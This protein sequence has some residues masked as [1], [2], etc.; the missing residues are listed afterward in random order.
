V[1]NKLL[2]RAS[3]LVIAL[4]TATAVEAGSAGATTRRDA[5]TPSRSLATALHNQRRAPSELAREIAHRSAHGAISPRGV[6]VTH[7][8]ESNFDPA[9]G[10]PNSISCAT[11]SN[12]VM[13][14][15]AGGVS[16]YNGSTWSA[17]T[18]VDA[19][20]Q[21]ASISCPTSTFCAATDYEGNWLFD[22][23]GTWTTPTPFNATTPADN[24]AESISC[25]S[26]TFCV[27]VGY[28]QSGANFGTEIDFWDGG[29]WYAQSGGT[30]SDN[31]SAVSCKSTSFCLAVTYFG[32]STVISNPHVDPDDATNELVDLTTPTAIDGTNFVSGMTSVSCASTTYCAAGTNEGY[33]EVYNGA[34][35]TTTSIFQSFVAAGYVS[36]PSVTSGVANA[37]STVCFAMNEAGE[38]A[39]SLGNTS[40]T[41]GPT[42]SPLSLV[43]GLTCADTANCEASDF[44]GRIWA[45]ALSSVFPQVTATSS[46]GTFD[47]PHFMSGLSCTSSTLCV[48][49]D[50][51]GN[52]FQMTG[53]T[54]SS[55]VP[56][57]ARPYGI[58]TLACSPFTL[59]KPICTAFDADG[60]QYI[61]DGTSWSSSKSA[62]HVF[63]DGFS[64]TSGSICWGVDDHFHAYHFVTRGSAPATTTMPSNDPNNAQPMGLS[65]VN[66]TKFCA[67]IDD[68]GYG[69]V[70]TGTTWSATKAFDNVGTPTAISCAS[71]TFCMVVDDGGRAFTWNGKAWSGARFVAKDYLGAVSCSS[72]FRCVASDPDGIGYIWDGFQWTE[73][74]VINAPGDGLATLSCAT[75]NKCEAVNSQNLFTLTVTPSKTTSAI[76]PISAANRVVDHVAPTVV[77]TGSTVPFGT[78]TIT[79]GKVSCTAVLTPIPTAASKSSATCALAVPNVGVTVVSAVYHGALAT[80]PSLTGAVRLAVAAEPTKTAVALSTSVVKRGAEQR[81]RFTAFVYPGYPGLTAVGTVTI[82]TAG[83]ALCSIALHNGAGACSLSPSELP[84]GTFHVSALYH[85]SATMRPSSSPT[86][87]LTVT[88]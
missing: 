80:N 64:C 67:A 88:S 85:G 86:K 37:F 36:C 63:Y 45:V 50:T 15:N 21:L 11:V 30:T 71:V 46:A 18:V 38:T 60:T 24:V 57:T 40:W 17:V 77:V 42:G 4:A 27:A 58:T 44:T 28:N 29:H 14:D 56:L 33:L 7:W 70:T 48:A 31:F 5:L 19:G 78:V 81:A 53:T 20:N 43:S 6:T 47:P 76:M 59:N 16:T 3:V 83:R 41:Q 51:A 1:A 23:S 61:F 49:S 74:P 73:T 62:P 8:V 9:Q 12:C 65:C 52:I 87:T 25:P 75:A 55:A 35:W 2:R 69:Y 54:W 39:Y 34:A 66:A 82:V 68:D 84:V 22:N 26:A 13:V 32:L 72:P 10:G 79:N